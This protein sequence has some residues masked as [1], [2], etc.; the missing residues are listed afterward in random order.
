M[1]A[2]ENE[3]LPTVHAASDSSAGSKDWADCGHNVVM[4][5]FSEAIY[6]QMLILWQFPQFQSTC[7]VDVNQSPA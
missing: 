3:A 2:N 4:V 7:R 6:Q 5:M 1:I